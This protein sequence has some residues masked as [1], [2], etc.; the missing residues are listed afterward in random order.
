[1]ARYW[2]VLLVVPFRS[3]TRIVDTACICFF[4]MFLVF[5]RADFIFLS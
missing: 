2:H 3:G 1:M 5:L 4:H